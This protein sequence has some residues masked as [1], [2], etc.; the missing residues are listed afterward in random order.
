[1]IKI[2][3]NSC[4]YKIQMSGHAEYAEQGKDIVCSAASILLYTLADTVIKNEEMLIHEPRI[5]IE[6]ENV[7]YVQCIPKPEY[8]ANISTI[9]Q[10]IL[11]GFELLQEGYPD[12]LKIEN[13]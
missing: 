1:M 8:R 2:K 5:K 12:N 4:T 9:Y 10:T 6:A 13:I 3:V 7:C 11:N